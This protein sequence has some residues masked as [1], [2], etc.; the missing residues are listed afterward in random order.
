MNRLLLRACFKTI[1]APVLKATMDEP[2]K[3]Q[4]HC[5]ERGVFAKKAVWRCCD[6]RYSP[7]R[8]CAGRR[9][10]PSSL[11][12]ENGSHPIF[13]TGSEDNGLGHAGC[14]SGAADDPRIEGVILDSKGRP[15]PNA[16][17][18]VY[19]AKPRE[20][21]ATMCATCYPDCGK[22]ARTDDQG[23]FKI[24]KLNGDL[25][26]RLLVTAKGWRVD[27]ITDADPLFGSVEQR[28]KP[29]RWSDAPLDRKVIGKIIDSDGKSVAGAVL[30]IDG[31]RNGPY[32]VITAGSKERWK[33]LAARMK[34]ANS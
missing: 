34:T 12:G 27:Y 22:K 13:K 17:V 26:Y 16:S 23:Q 21:E 10:E 19:S 5:G 6:I 11:F 9:A 18:Y 3:T 7:Q 8:G 4:N 15:I 14:H 1:K 24:E 29:H 25:L 20:G 33:R 32:Q 30:N 2:L 31:Y 28:L